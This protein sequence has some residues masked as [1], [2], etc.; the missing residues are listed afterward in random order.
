MD[1]YQAIVS[2]TDWL[3]KPQLQGQQIR[4]WLR[5]SNQSSL[6]LLD[7]HFGQ[8]WPAVVVG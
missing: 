2:I 8:Q 3:L 4:Q 7:Q 5:A 6:P 1:F